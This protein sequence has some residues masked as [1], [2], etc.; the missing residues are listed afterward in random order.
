MYKNI[1]YELAHKY[2]NLQK[3]DPLWSFEERVGEGFLVL[4]K[5][6]PKK[7]VG[8]NLET[9]LWTSLENRF[10]EIHRK[11]TTKKRFAVFE[12]GEAV[13]ELLYSNRNPNINIKPIKPI[14]KEEIDWSR[15][16]ELSK[17]AREV[18][19]IIIQSPKEL[20]QICNGKNITK[21]TLEIFLR[22]F[23]G[24]KTNKIRNFFRSLK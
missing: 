12:S 15:I 19:E 16:S 13:S 5:I 3:L 22:D 9:L 6:L 17:E 1:I 18:V 21:E 8:R 23:R 4:T 20:L 11:L 10:K 24:W 14:S 2:H 7:E